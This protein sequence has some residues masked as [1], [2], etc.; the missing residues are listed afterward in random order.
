MTRIISPKQVRDAAEIIRKGGVVAFPTETVYGL[1]ASALNPDA[2]KKIFKAKG[3]PSDNPLIVHI[4]GREQLKKVARIPKNKLAIVNKL[5]RKFW[6]GPLTLILPRK[7]IVPLEVTGGLGTVAVRM[8]KSRIALRLIRMAGVPIA[9]PSA[10]ISG[11]P[12]GTCFEHVY[13]DFNGKIDGIIKSRPCKIGV[14]STVLDLTSNVPFI[15]RPGGVTYEQ[16]RKVLPGIKIYTHKRKVKVVKSP[17]MKYK[18]YSPKAK[19]LLFED[20][21]M[22]RIAEYKKRLE[23]KGKRVVVISPKNSVAFSR[24]LFAMFRECDKKK[25]EYILMPAIE[26]K[27]IGLAIMNRIR[28]AAS[29][30]LR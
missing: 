3:R 27:G 30:I 16:L 5:I 29:R 12:S 22:R 14:E 20:G 2:A 6:P 11:K 23:R 13:D 26:E 17:G 19:V 4:A 9:A 10:N 24:K 15:L 1:G 7:E 25:I 21:E 28:K 8:P 18:H